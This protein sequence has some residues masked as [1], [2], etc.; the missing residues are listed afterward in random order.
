MTRFRGAGGP[1]PIVKQGLGG[2]QGNPFEYFS[3]PVGEE[4]LRFKPFKLRCGDKKTVIVLDEGPLDYSVMMHESFKTPDG[5]YQNNAVC[6]AN[7]PDGKGCPL[8]EVAEKP[9]IWFLCATVIDESEFT[10]TTGRNAGVTYSHMRRLLLISNRNLEDFVE[11]QSDEDEVG[12][13]WRGVRYRVK[14]SSD[15]KSRK[16]GT[17]WKHLGRLSEDDLRRELVSTAANKKVDV[18]DYVKPIDYEA[19]LAPVSYE[20]MKVGAENV[21]FA[22]T[23]SLKDAASRPEEEIPF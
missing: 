5:K 19:A 12:E 3:E 7:A 13:D 10:P 15:Q 8:C 23:Q 6:R 11:M 18:T 16:I 20:D 9:A 14:R 21:G 4:S 1:P 17:S 22:F 2:F